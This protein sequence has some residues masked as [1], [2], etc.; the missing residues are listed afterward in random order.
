M[1]VGLGVI[2]SCLSTLNLPF[3]RDQ[4]ASHRGEIPRVWQTLPCVPERLGQGSTGLLWAPGWIVEYKKPE[5]KIHVW[6][7]VDLRERGGRLVLY[8]ALLWGWTS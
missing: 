1:L 5:G 2:C 4:P 7:R 3:S 6:V 8:Q